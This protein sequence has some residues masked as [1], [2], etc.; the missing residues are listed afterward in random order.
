MR[1]LHA[2]AQRPGRTGSGVFLQQLF[3][4]GLEKGYEQAVLAGVPLEEKEPDIDNLDIKNFY[5]IL[6]ETAELPFPVVGMSDI[7]PYKSTKYS[8]IDETM[9]NMYE[10]EFKKVIKKA[11]EEFKPDVVIS[12]HIW[13]LSTFIKDLYPNLKTLVLC[14]GTDLR[15]MEL[16]KHLLP[17]V[18]EKIPKCDYLFALNSVQAQ[19][20]KNLYDVEDEQVITSGS[21]YNPQM[22]FPIKREKNKKVKITYVGKIANAKGLPHLINAIENTTNCEHLELNLIGKGSGDESKNIIESIKTKKADIKYLGALPQNELENQLRHSDIFILPSFY[23]GLPLVV[24]EALASGAKVIA[25]DLPGLD[26]F[27]GDKI[28]ELDA[29]RYISMPKLET[30]DTPYQ[31]EIECFEK[32]ITS[33]LDEVSNEILNDKEYK[34]DEV[35]KL[36]ED[37]TWLGLFNRLEKRF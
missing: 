31:N 36:L 15:Q 30:V 9:Y 11:V 26:D 3:K 17:I 14:H 35:I 22:F 18:K 16:S 8:D 28:K 27:L 13:L 10:K 25:T 19:S 29:I 23:E 20:I 5:P 2:L 1:I 6:F 12:N 33:K 24:I 37:K 7:M 21:G 32:D 4:A 34:I